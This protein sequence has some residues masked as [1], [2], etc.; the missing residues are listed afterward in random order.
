MRELKNVLE[1]SIL[2]MQGKF[3]EVGDLPPTVTTGPAKL[4]GRADTGQ[5]FH[6]SDTLAQRVKE[7]EK[8][9]VL[10]AVEECGDSLAGKKE[11]AKKLGISLAALYNKLN[12]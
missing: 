9:Q 5:N 10:S 2:M 3:I 1:Y 4:S 12:N 6:S 11:A 8:G 7:F